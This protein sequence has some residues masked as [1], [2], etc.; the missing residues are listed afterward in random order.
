MQFRGKFETGSPLNARQLEW[1][2]VRTAQ[3]EK[4]NVN[5]ASRPEVRPWSDQQRRKAATVLRPA[6]YGIR[7][8]AYGDKTL[9]FQPEMTRKM[10]S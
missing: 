4:F 1:W 2:Y 5:S 6:R 10:H 9:I 7:K 8:P 3:L